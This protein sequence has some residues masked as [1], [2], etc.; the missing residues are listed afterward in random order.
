M[1]EAVCIAKA[2]LARF[3]L[4]DKGDS[5][6]VFAVFVLA[7][8]TRALA[9][10]DVEVLQ[11]L[12]GLREALMGMAQRDPSRLADRNQRLNLFSSS[13]VPSQFGGVFF[14]LFTFL[15]KAHPT[16]SPASDEAQ[17][18]THSGVFIS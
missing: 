12:P 18:P 16:I 17:N 10:L 8:F 5:K 3:E 4:C 11:V 14:P 7:V 15:T 6:G 2:L 1:A 9:D 13:I